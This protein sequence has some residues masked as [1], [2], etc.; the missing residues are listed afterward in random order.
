M[1]RFD[2]FFRQK[3]KQG[4]LDAAFD[5]AE[6]AINN[7]IA[8]F[9]YVGV[10][11][12]A[13]VSEANPT[14]NFTVDV[15][16][17]GVC[18]DQLRQ[19]IAWPS[20][21]NVNCLVDELNVGTAVAGAGNT[22][23]LTIFAEFKRIE[24]QD[25]ID[26]N[27]NPLKFSLAEG[28]Q[29]NVVQG[30]EGVAPAKPSV[31]GDQILLADV[32]IAFGQTVIVTGDVDNARRAFVFNLTGSPLSI[33]STSLT[34][35]LQ[36]MLNVMNNL[37]GSTIPFGGAP[38]WNGGGLLLPTPTDLDNAISTVVANLAA[39][40]GP[41]GETGSERVGA[42]QVDATATIRTSGQLDAGSIKA[43]L[44]QVLQML[45]HR[46]A[47]NGRATHASG[48]P[49][50]SLISSADVAASGKFM[51]VSE[52]SIAGDSR[53]GRVYIQADNGGGMVA[54]WNAKFDNTTELWDY[55][56]SAFNATKVA[57]STGA[58][59]GQMKLDSQ[60]PWNNSSW[61]AD[62]G[63]LLQHGGFKRYEAGVHP[64][65]FLPIGAGGLPATDWAYDSSTGVWTPTTFGAS[66]RMICPIN[67]HIPGGSFLRSI[68]WLVDPGVAQSV[69]V[70]T[71]IRDY[72]FPGGTNDPSFNGQTNTSDG[73]AAMQE[74]RVP[75][76]G[77]LHADHRA[78][79]SATGFFIDASI[80]V[81][82]GQENN[83][84]VHGVLLEFGVQEY[85][86]F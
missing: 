2:F 45:N 77:D 58:I 74:I 36:D 59:F 22:K 18:Y 50:L 86:S 27:L 12:N 71:N 47:K 55:D 24:S 64:S 23:W 15:A 25:R 68:R 49:D 41:A 48:D 78:I 84:G 61:E 76:S 39:Q 9:D 52:F 32:L 20:T 26:G 65:S 42:D 69:Q 29:L 60:A 72:S 16:G 51:L 13:E 38:T 81:V 28:F 75:A 73:T 17:P 85:G 5:A 57:I 4:E 46:N 54:T 67:G 79:R 3:V 35:V 7:F 80:A 66:M 30:S 21:Q 83:L 44:T 19:R 37:D 62:A 40:T 53:K 1:D 82:S 6:N 10:V 43:Q 70:A 11:K 31:R 34:T 8:D 56:E 14:A 63:P 33:Q